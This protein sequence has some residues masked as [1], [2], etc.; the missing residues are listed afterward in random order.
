MATTNSGLVAGKVITGHGSNGGGRRGLR[1]TLAAGVVI[2]GCVAA[3]TFGGLRMHSGAQ[4]Q[5]APS[6]AAQ[7]AASVILSPIGRTG[8]ADE[9]VQGGLTSVLPV[10]QRTGPADEYSQAESVVALRITHGNGAADEYNQI[11][12]VVTTQLT[13]GSGAADEYER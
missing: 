13:H 3:L 10:M 11:A 12:E 7:P 6:A 9:Y 4:T 1:T 8:P 5:P 2:L